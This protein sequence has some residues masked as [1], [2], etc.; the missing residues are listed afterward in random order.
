MTSAS[1]IAAVQDPFAAA[2]VHKI[3]LR[4]VPFLFAIFVVA[5]VDRINIGFAALTMNKDL[6][7]ASQQFGFL[8]GIFFFGH[9]L[10]E[11]PSNYLLH[12][13][14][15]RVWIARILLTWG[16]IATLTGFV[17]SVHQLYVM[18]FLLGASPKLDTS[19]ESFFTSPIGS[20]SPIWHKPLRCS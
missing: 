2:T 17:Q 11:I 8:S 9:F 20:V 12:K 14:G 13:I 5:F 3:S 10:F 1:S 16:L 6:A 4:L 19:P 7:I 15:A 18:R